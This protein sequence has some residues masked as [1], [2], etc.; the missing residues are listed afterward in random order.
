MAAFLPPSPILFRRTLFTT[1]WSSPAMRSQS[2]FLLGS[3]LIAAIGARAARPIPA[4]A[5]P[6]QIGL[7]L[8]QATRGPST[9]PQQTRLHQQKADEYLREKRPD[10]AIPEFSAVVAAEPEN[11]DAQANLGVLLFFAG[12][13]DEAEPHLRAALAINPS[14]SKL[15]MLLGT[16]E[17]RQGHLE[18]A[19]R[20]ITAALP[21]ITDPKVRQQ[22]GLEIIEIDTTLD[23][24]PAAANVAA[25]LKKEFPK[26]P[27]V[28][29][30]S[31]QV[32][33]DLADEAVLDLSLADPQS[34]QMHQAMAHVLIRERDNKAAIENLRE[35][36]KINPA[37]P[38]AHYELAELLRL[39]TAPADKSEAT[40]QYKLA[41]QYQP[42][43]AA[44]LTRLGDIA[45][46]AED[47]TTAIARY[48]Q[49]LAAQPQY[50]DAQIG[51]AYELSETGHLD[52]AVP[53]LK[54]A[55]SN[56]PMSMLAHFRLSAVYRR[57]HQPEDA[58]RE[59]AEYE[60]LKTMKDNLRNIYDTMR[61]DSPQGKDVTR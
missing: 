7:M 54:Q 55:I 48:K 40:E 11:L 35:A 53:L 9:P 42:N 15:R 51:L 58:K 29:F 5:L 31:W 34:A 33:S 8:Q 26:D 27:E 24:L 38:G 41:I 18:D 32:F 44:S 43:D 13:P 45:G 46:E 50:T 23:D 57:L 19:R 47:H 22:A 25:Q 36:L 20:D 56:D 16:S 60:K 2:R 30:A 39:S 17:H 6:S 4:Q 12:K 59:L 10:L 37:L 52:Q 49:A 28:L 61:L 14:L 21:E 3:I 1:G